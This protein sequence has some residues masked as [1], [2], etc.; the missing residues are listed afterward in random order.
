[1][2]ILLSTLPTS[3]SSTRVSW[4][5]ILYRLCGH[6]GHLVA[7]NISPTSVKTIHYGFT[8]AFGHRKS[9]R[10]GFLNQTTVTTTLICSTLF[11]T[12]FLAI[13][14]LIFSAWVVHLF[15]KLLLIGKLH[16]VTRW[17]LT[18]QISKMGVTPIFSCVLQEVLGSY[19]VFFQFW[20]P[21]I[22]FFFKI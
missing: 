12:T 18:S 2:M 8:H 10:S 5:L 14:F 19:T 13:V 20:C 22:W 6:G 9:V 1:M 7:K 15:Q 16:S 3:N 17:F 4:K 21:V 11:K